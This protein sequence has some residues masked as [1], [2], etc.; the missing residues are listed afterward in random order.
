MRCDMF[1][2]ARIEYVYLFH[3]SVNNMGN[4]GKACSAF[5]LGRDTGE[6]ACQLHAWVGELRRTAGC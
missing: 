2:G 6:G 1:K 4:V 3:G 5:R